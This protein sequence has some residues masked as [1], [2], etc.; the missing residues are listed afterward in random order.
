[1]NS[2][3]WLFSAGMI[4]SASTLLYQLT[5]EIVERSNLGR[6]EGYAPEAQ[7]PL[8]AQRS[9]PSLRVFKAHVCTPELEA[10]AKVGRAIV[11]YSYR[12]IRDVAV[13]AM[14]KFSFPTLSAL[15]ESGWLQ[16]AATDF[17]KW[18]A[19]PRVHVVRYENFVTD[20]A[21]EARAINLFIG[22]P[23]DHDAASAL[24]SEFTFE[25]QKDRI[26]QIPKPKD[27]AEVALQT[28]FDRHHLLHHNHLHLGEVGKWRELLTADEKRSLQSHFGAWLRHANYAIDE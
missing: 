3:E 11:I 2:V 6:R 8:L 7:F 23:L 25:K 12:D 10:T 17:Y 16:R 21:A 28:N 9:E 13:S 1:M 5:S 27:A 24:A 4:R 15:L 18:T 14:R 26:R 22:A 19:M 20:I